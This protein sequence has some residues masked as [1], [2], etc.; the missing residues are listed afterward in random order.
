M[1]TIEGGGS[2]GKRP[3]ISGVDQFAMACDGRLMLMHADDEIELNRGDTVLIRAKT[4]HR[5]HNPWEESAQ[6][7]IVSS[8]VV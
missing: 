8:R 4:P 3:S 1:V 5:W 7:L 6:V 2:S